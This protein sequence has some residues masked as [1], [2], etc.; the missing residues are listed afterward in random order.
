MGVLL[1]LCAIPVIVYGL[2]TQPL[3]IGLGLLVIV[4]FAIWAYQDEK[5]RS[6]L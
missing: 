5:R 4:L 3:A 2:I 1:I 6:R